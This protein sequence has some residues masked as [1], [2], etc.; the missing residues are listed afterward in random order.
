MSEW[1]EH[2]GVGLHWR[3]DGDPNGPPVLMLN[4][5]GTDL[6]LWDPILPRLKGAFELIVL[7]LPGYGNDTAYAG[8]FTLT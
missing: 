5:L 3:E 8:A 6:R 2:N 1:F 4:S 7:D